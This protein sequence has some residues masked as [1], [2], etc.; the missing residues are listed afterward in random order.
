MSQN[1]YLL[2]CLGVL[3]L[4]AFGCAGNNGPSSSTPVQPPSV[5]SPPA[6]SPPSTV[7]GAPTSGTTGSSSVQLGDSDISPV[8]EPN[9]NVIST[10][11][12]APPDNSA[13]AAAAPVNGQTLSDDDVAVAN[14]TN[15]NAI[16]SGD[17]VE[18]S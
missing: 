10:Q 11:D 13:V 17:V 6:Q 16:S 12:V 3:L 14:D 9:E 2:G 15:E 8:D 7:T 18:P 1:I 4:L 5:Q